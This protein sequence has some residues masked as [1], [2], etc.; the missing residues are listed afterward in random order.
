MVVPNFLDPFLSFNN[1]IGLIVFEGILVFF[2][3]FNET[4]SLH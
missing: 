3:F 4:V 1:C 2:F